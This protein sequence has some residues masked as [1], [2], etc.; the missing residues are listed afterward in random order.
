MSERAEIDRLAAEIADALG[1][2]GGPGQA[3]RAR[4]EAQVARMVG[5]VG[6]GWLRERATEAWKEFNIR[7]AWSS[8]KD[9][10]KRTLGGVFFELC[11]RDGREL[12]LQRKQFYRTFCW[13]EPEPPKVRVPKAPPPKQESKRP[14]GERG[15]TEHASPGNVRRRRIVQTEVY[16]RR[17]SR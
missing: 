14:R 15:Q 9:G 8:R 4:V 1:E 16:V 12:Q 10:G 5:V 7:G 2:T 6:E 17:A 11:R 13:R 3:P